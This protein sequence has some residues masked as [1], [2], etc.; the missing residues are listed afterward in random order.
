MISLFLWNIVLGKAALPGQDLSITHPWLSKNGYHPLH[1]KSRPRDDVIWPILW[2]EGI[3]RL[4]CQQ[5]RGA[6]L[7]FSASVISRKDCQSHNVNAGTLS[8]ILSCIQP[9]TARSAFL[10]TPLLSF[11]LPSPSDIHYVLGSAARAVNLLALSRF[12]DLNI[13]DERTFETCRQLSAACSHRLQ[14]VS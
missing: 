3:C 6:H 14:S 5:I 10:Y 13:Y 11:F 8:H 7:P 4:R 2:H 1:H 9:R 12:W